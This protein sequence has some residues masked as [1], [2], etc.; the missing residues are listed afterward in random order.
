[1]SSTSTKRPRVTDDASTQQPDVRHVRELEGE[2]ENFHEIARHL[3]PEPG[4]LPNVAGFDIHG[5]TMPL[6]GVLG[7]D[8]L[9]PGCRHDGGQLTQARRASA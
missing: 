1:M 4:D 6:S 3:M 8:H 5:E 7:G 9:A 2:L